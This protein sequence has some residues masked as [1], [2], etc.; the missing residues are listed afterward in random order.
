MKVFLR[1]QISAD[2]LKLEQRTQSFVR[3]LA[4]FVQIEVLQQDKCFRFLRRLLNYDRWRIDG[5]LQSGQF[6]DYQAAAK[7]T[8][9]WRQNAT[10]CA[11]G[12]ALSASS[13]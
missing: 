9:M 2:L 12:I 8:P 7:L 4:D 5:R 10:I 11:S 13:R 1:E 3:Q 6:L